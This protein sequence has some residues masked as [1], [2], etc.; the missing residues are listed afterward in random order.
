V[1]LLGLKLEG[2]QVDE[3]EDEDVE[4][5]TRATLFGV[6]PFTLSKTDS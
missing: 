6:S 4:G 3:A 1:G 2:T 5:E